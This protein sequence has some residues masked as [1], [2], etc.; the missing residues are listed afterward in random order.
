[1]Q[2]TEWDTSVKD[3]AETVQLGIHLKL[4][5]GT[6]IGT[7]NDCPNQTCFTGKMLIVVTHHHLRKQ[8][9]W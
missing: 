5:L 4:L 7:V 8:T 3:R 2:G 1:M 6:V 9:L